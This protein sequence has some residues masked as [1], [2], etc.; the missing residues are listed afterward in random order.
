[1][2][3]GII[4]IVILLPIPIVLLFIVLHKDFD[5][6]TRKIPMPPK[7]LMPKQCKHKWQ[8]RGRNRYGI[9]T[10]RLCL[11]CRETQERVNNLGEPEKFDKCKP[12][13]WLD[14]QF[15]KNDNYIS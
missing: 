2:I 11:K 3:Y 8:T 4:T 10:Y 7:H 13:Q 1:M 15:D 5:G 9:T 6:Y 12:N 14:A